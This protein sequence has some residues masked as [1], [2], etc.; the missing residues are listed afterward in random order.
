MKKPAVWIAVLFCALV[1][2]YLVYSSLTTARFRCE[3]CI[4][5]DGRH[6]C[7]VASAETRQQAVRAATDNAC[8]QVAS[9]VSESTRCAQI[10]PDSV[11]W[12][13]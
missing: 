7:R 13:Q 5:F 3:V 9:G 4:T 1:L 11:R 10:Q 12:L 8:A 2:G 6:D